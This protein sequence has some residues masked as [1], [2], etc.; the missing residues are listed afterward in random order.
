MRD[1]QNTSSGRPRDIPKLGLTNRLRNVIEKYEAK[2]TLILVVIVAVAIAVLAYVAGTAG[3]YFSSSMRTPRAVVVVLEGLNPA[4]FESA[5]QG[6]KAPNF[7][8]LTSNGGLY[9][10]ASSNT[11]SSAAAL[12]SILSGTGQ[13]YHNVSDWASVAKFFP[14]VRSFLGFGKDIQLRPV[15]IAPPKMF[16]G[17]I[18]DGTGVCTSLG[19]LD[20]ECSSV[21]C[22]SEGSTTAY[23]NVD[24]KQ[25]LCSGAAQLFDDSI[26]TTIIQQ[27]NKKSGVFYVQLDLLA[28]AI[29]DTDNSLSTLSSIFQVDAFIG[30]LSRTLSSMSLFN[31]QSWMLI[32]TGDGA[33]AAQQA[34][35]FMTT[36]VQGQQA[37]LKPLQLPTQL[38][39]ILPTVLSWFGPVVPKTIPTGVIQGVCSDGITPTSC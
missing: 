12:A 26:L 2:P 11:S 27:S 39:D 18:T 30:R 17:T 5:M 37:A 6:N 34:P 20:V 7:R 23:C 35:F 22:P 16:S 4:T 15:A 9:T 25:Q 28:N 3:T 33:N 24:V 29:D 10:R 8:F 38:I 32:V 19:L 31:A 1:F 13:Q 36:Y 21:G 14:N